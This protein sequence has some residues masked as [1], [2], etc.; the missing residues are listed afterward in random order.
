MGKYVIT[1]DILDILAG[2]TDGKSGEIR[3]A[4]AFEIALE[5]ESDIRA[6]SLE[7]LWLD[8]GDKLNFVKA[9]VHFGLKHPKIGEALRAHLHDLSHD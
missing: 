7:G 4:D 3:L 2:M 6:K 9:T 1:P 5:R 8:T